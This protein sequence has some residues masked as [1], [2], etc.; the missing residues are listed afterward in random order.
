MSHRRLA[1]LFLLSVALLAT[2]MALE[3]RQTV[4]FDDDSEEPCR[5]LS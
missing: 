4:G 3:Q 1:L 2:A 5:I